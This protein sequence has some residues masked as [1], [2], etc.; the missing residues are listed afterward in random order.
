MATPDIRPSVELKYQKNQD[1]PVTILAVI[2]TSLCVGWQILP[3][4]NI[5]FCL[6][7]SDFEVVQRSSSRV[8]P[9]ATASM[10]LNTSDPEVVQL[11]PAINLN[12]S[13][14]PLPSTAVVNANY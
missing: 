8:L 1:F 6:R 4:S 7:L 10:G 14:G 12:Q 2:T 5:P 11:D 9:R 13:Q 3:G